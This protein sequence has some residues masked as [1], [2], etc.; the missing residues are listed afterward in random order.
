MCRYLALFIA[1]STSTSAALM[2]ARRWAP[3][4]TAKSRMLRTMLQGGEGLR[5]GRIP[6]S[7]DRVPVMEPGWPATGSRKIGETRCSTMFRKGPTPALAWNVVQTLRRS[8]SRCPTP[9]NGICP[10]YRIGLGWRRLGLL[11][12]IR[13]MAVLVWTAAHC[14]SKSG[15]SLLAYNVSSESN[16]RRLG[17]PF[18]KL[19]RRIFTAWEQREAPRLNC[20]QLGHQHCCW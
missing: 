11:A 16:R 5:A 3:A 18:A 1:G 13:A 8:V 2:T 7:I 9:G 6:A 12:L 20:A 17:Y 19:F 4:A 15:P 14:T 10:P